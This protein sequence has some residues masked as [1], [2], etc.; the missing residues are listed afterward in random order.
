MIMFLSSIKKVV[1]KFVPETIAKATIREEHL[2][3]QLSEY[4]NTIVCSLLERLDRMQNHL[5]YVTDQIAHS[6]FWKEI[7]RLGQDYRNAKTSHE[8]EIVLSFLNSEQ[9][10]SVDNSSTVPLSDILFISFPY[11]DVISPFSAVPSLC[12]YLNS[13]GFTTAQI[14]LGILSFHYR[15]KCNFEHWQKKAQFFLSEEFFKNKVE[16]HK[17][18]HCKSYKEYHDKYSFLM[19]PE[20]TIAAIKEKVVSDKLG[21]ALFYFLVDEFNQSQKENL[22]TFSNRKFHSLDEISDWAENSM[23]RNTI[24]YFRLWDSIFQHKIIGISIT[25]SGQIPSAVFFA[26]IVKHFSPD[27]KIIL[28][29]SAVQH[30]EALTPEEKL[31]KYFDFVIEH[32]GET[33]LT[34]L[35]AFLKNSIGQLSDIPNLKYKVGNNVFC[36]ENILED[37]TTLPP[38][39]YDGLDLS[40][41]LA[42]HPI[43]AYQASR[44]CF[45]G[46]CAFCNHDEAYRKNYRKKRAQQVVA[47]VLFLSQKYHV[48]DFQFVDEAIEPTFFQEIVSEMSNTSSFK[49]INW[50]YYSRISPKYT[51]ET[52]KAAKE[53]GC[54]MVM[55]GIESFNQRVLNF[56]RKGIRRKDILKNLEQFSKAGIR[57]HGWL[58]W[59][60][61]SETPQEISQDITDFQEN[62]KY[63]HTAWLGRF[64]LFPNCEIYNNLSQF[65]IT[66]H[67]SDDIY[68][69]KY[70]DADGNPVEMEEVIKTGIE[71]HHCIESCYFNENRYLAYFYS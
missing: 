64:G 46:R 28:G 19:D 41:Y 42:P 50:F 3:S 63:M 58:L 47:D 51:D 39:N 27:T 12:G 48:R 20:I 13:Q 53:H 36:N 8:K 56:I 10:L 2:H 70:I 4:Q 32:E 31:F 29:G 26:K 15:F 65:H 40:L 25:A 43:L 33:S 23:L 62:A 18:N 49:D 59:G 55:F 7:Y 38:P 14:D 17:I 9:S 69:F 30:L 60:L 1:K 57:V 44:G 67:D 66:A 5:T 35:L 54:S 37:V 61:P 68:D 52:L 22:S 21:G 24:G 6:D 45:Y 71:Y 11:W 16:K 34:R